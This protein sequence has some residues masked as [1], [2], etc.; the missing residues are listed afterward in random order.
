MLIR[1]ALRE[2]RTWVL[3]SRHWNDYQP[4][5]DDIIVCTYPKSGTTWMQRIVNLLIFQT[6]EARPVDLLSPWID[7][8]F[9]KPIAEVWPI[10]NVQ[11]HRRAFKSHL[12]LDGLPLYDRVSYI[13]VARDGRDAAMS[14][15]NHGTGF[16]QSFQDQADAIG[17]ADETIAKPY[18]RVP[19]EPAEYFQKWLR[20][21]L[22]KDQTS[23]FSLLAYFEFERTYWNE[24][25]RKN[26]LLVNYADMKLDLESEMR[27]V[28]DFLNI[29]ISSTVWPALVKAAEFEAMK[30]QGAEIMPGVSKIFAEGADRFFNKGINGRWRG[31][32]DQEDLDLY[33]AKLKATLPTACIKWLEFGRQGA[34]NPE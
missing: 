30:K 20:V 10:V 1:P 4:R 14:F 31:V 11:T 28:A 25:R 9:G 13:H 24:R 12:P 26:L 5:A 17:L 33:D 16:N 6:D 18:P 21:G 2:Y 7:R 19:Q 8:R 23:G 3:D 29:N 32:F 27:R 15:H 22:I 34:T